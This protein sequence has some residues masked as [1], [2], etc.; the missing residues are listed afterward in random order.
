[1]LYSS[2]RSY[3]RTVKFHR[4][5]QAIDPVVPTIHEIEFLQEQ[6]ESS[7][8][9][10]QSLICQMYSFINHPPKKRNKK[11]RSETVQIHMELA[12]T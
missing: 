7:V 4:L 3:I 5:K 12:K 11:E 6:I 8:Y 9:N 1:M 2:G 10:M